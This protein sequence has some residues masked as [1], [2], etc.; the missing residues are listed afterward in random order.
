MLKQ[1]ASEVVARAVGGESI[2]I[3]DRGR[4]VAR[5]TPLMESPVAELVSEGL[6]RPAMRSLSTLP[7]PTV[8]GDISSVLR[9][10]RDEERY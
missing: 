2:T 9:Q 4:P 3:T 6:A 5:L 1:N 7:A 10:M 8:A